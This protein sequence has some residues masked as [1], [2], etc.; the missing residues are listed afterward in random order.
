LEKRTKRVKIICVCGMGMGSGLLIKMGVDNI[1]KKAGYRE[2][3]WIC[4]VCDVSTARQTGID[5]YV[6]TSEF[7]RNLKDTPAKLVEVKNLF[8]EKEIAKGLIPI[9]KELVDE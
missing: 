1:L 9:Y 6:T 2:G 8:D 3:T 4:E 7:S 5:I